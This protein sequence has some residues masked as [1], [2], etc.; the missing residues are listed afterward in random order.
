VFDDII[1]PAEKFYDG[2]DSPIEFEAE[3]EVDE[4]ANVSYSFSDLEKVLNIE[5][6]ELEK[7]I[8]EAMEL[9]F[10]DDDCGD[11]CDGCNTCNPPVP[12]TE[13][14]CDK[15]DEEKV[16]DDQLLPTDDCDTQCADADCCGCENDE[17]AHAVPERP[18]AWGI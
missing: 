6:S 14:E 15:E 8:D 12:E 1:K 11:G 9:L 18:K 17:G 5:D 7:A 13:P 3:F 10:G 4:D 16:Y 2:D